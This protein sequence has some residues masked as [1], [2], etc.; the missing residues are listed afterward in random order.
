MYQLVKQLNSTIQ[1]YKTILSYYKILVLSCS[2]KVRL[3]SLSSVSVAGKMEGDQ[4]NS[5][6]QGL[7]QNC[8]QCSDYEQHI[9]NGSK[10]P[11]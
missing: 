1:H 6:S 5:G 11:A 10:T 8:P 7:K 3:F 2:F 4:K 9:G